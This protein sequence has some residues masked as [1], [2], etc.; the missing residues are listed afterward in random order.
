MYIAA[1]RDLGGVIKS[2]EIS[3]EVSAKDRRGEQYSSAQLTLRP[4]NT[5]MYISYIIRAPQ[6]QN[7]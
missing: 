7:G 1:C 2:K 4:R 5:A 6:A 3:V